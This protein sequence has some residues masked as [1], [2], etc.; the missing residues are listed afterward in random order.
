MH[1]LKA[2]INCC[3][4]PNGV[5][6]LGI[7][8][9]RR[10]MSIRLP[11]DAPKWA[12]M[13][14]ADGCC[15]TRSRECQ[16]QC[17]LPSSECADF[18]KGVFRPAPL[19]M[20]SRPSQAKPLTLP[21]LAPPYKICALRVAEL[22]NLISGQMRVASQLCDCLWS[23]SSVHYQHLGFSDSLRALLGSGFST[24]GTDHSCHSD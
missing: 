17:C 6:S 24:S 4:L 19:L 10:S 22:C 21:S 14:C 2:C 12:V 23:L 11:A 16:Y 13:I 1:L 20:R 7:C 9:A 8:N 15:A 5:S 3:S 18:A